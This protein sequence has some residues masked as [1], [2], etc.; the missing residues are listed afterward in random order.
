MLESNNR[1]ALDS[2]VWELQHFKC[3]NSDILWLVPHLQTTDQVV[4]RNAEKCDDTC[5]FQNCQKWPRTS[6][7]IIHFDN[8]FC[9]HSSYSAPNTRQIMVHPSPVIY[10]TCDNIIQI[11]DAIIQTYEH[12]WQPSVYHSKTFIGRST[13]LRTFLE[14]LARASSADERLN[15]WFSLDADYHGRKFH[16]GAELLWAKTLSQHHYLRRK[17]MI[18]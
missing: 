17:H 15:Q 18:L 6:L 13:D 16:L 5:V 14:S 8:K 4:H 7:S 1:S 2:E 9:H 3:A 11:C 10:S 12:I